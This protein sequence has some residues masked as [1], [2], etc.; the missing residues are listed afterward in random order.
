MEID[1]HGVGSAALPFTI[2]S[3]FAMSRA[4]SD[5]DMCRSEPSAKRTPKKRVAGRV[6]VN[7]ALTVFLLAHV[8]PYSN[9]VQQPR[10]ATAILASRPHTRQAARFD[11]EQ[12]RAGSYGSDGRQVQPETL[13]VPVACPMTG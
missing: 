11:H 2:A 4:S 8:I 5:L 13:A 12:D 1:H 3:L 10:R 7:A 9:Q 6:D